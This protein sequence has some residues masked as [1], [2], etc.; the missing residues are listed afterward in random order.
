LALAATEFAAQF[1]QACGQNCFGLSYQT[2]LH[3]VRTCCCDASEEMLTWLAAATGAGVRQVQLSVHHGFYEALRWHL[4]HEHAVWHDHELLR[5]GMRPRNADLL[6]REARRRQPDMEE[7]AALQWMLP[8][9]PEL[10]CP[11]EHAEYVHARA[12][13][14]Q[15]SERARLGQRGPESRRRPQGES[16]ALALQRLRDREEARLERRLEGLRVRLGRWEEAEER[17]RQRAQARAQ[18]Q[19]RAR[20]QAQAK[21]PEALARARARAQAEAQAPEA[22]ALALAQAPALAPALAQALALAQAQAQAQAQ[23]LY[24]QAQP[25]VQLVS[26]KKRVEQE[27]MQAGQE[28]VQAGKL[29]LLVSKN[30]TGYLGVSLGNPGRPKPYEARVRRGGKKVSLG[31]FATAEEAALCFA[32]SPE[33]QAAAVERAAAA[34]ALTSEEAR[35]QA[36]AEGLTLRG[37]ESKTGYFGVG[38]MPGR[39]KPFEAKVSRGAATKQVRLGSFATAE[40]AALCVARSPEGQAAAGRAAAAESQGTLPAVPSGAI[41]KEEGTASRLCRPARSSRRKA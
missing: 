22:L 24:A 17:Q 37:A 15:R 9:V 12:K 27:Q 20:A 29:T 32:R 2:L 3:A 38:H 10:C 21:A 13:E 8:R 35:Q 40:E 5:A 16:Y 30:R 23:A 34:A 36:Q 6:L 14:S 26:T 41:L 19:A 1:S 33:G 39:S 31:S 18:A 4:A 11:V 7:L 25:Q 28:Q